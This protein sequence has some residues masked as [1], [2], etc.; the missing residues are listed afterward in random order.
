MG[1][2][3]SLMFLTMIRTKRWLQLW[4]DNRELGRVLFCFLKCDH[5]DSWLDWLDDNW[6]IWNFVFYFYSGLK[7]KCWE[8]EKVPGRVYLA[9]TG[10]G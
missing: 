1:I 7:L 2:G 10:T 6:K 3:D 5:Y 8:G 4:L 9:L